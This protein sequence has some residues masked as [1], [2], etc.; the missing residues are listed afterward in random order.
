MGMGEQG[1]RIPSATLSDFGK[2]RF[3]SGRVAVLERFDGA[4]WHPIGRFGSVLDAGVAL[5]DAIGAG[6]EPSSLRVVEV[7]RSTG[8][9]VLMIAGAVLF[10]VALVLVLF[11]VFG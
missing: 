7:P 4:A 8:M 10:V 3:R 9:R 6:A 5:D 1:P 11:L 2:G